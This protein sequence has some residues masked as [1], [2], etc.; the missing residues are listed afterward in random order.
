M[1]ARPI[2][3]IT[4]G[5]RGVGAAVARELAPTHGLILGGRESTTLHAICDELGARPWA[6]ELTDERAVAEA[7]AGI[8]R[9]DVL[10][11]SAGTAHLGRVADVPARQW[12]ESFEV[13][14]IAV[15][16]LT[17]L[18]LPALRASRGQV[19][20]INSG[21]GLR[22]NPGWAAY[23]ATKFAL[24]AFADA[25]RQEE[26]GDGVR[27]TSVFPGRVD[28]DLQRSVRE[29]EGGAYEPEKYLDAASVARAV[30]TAVT[31]SRDA[32][33]TEIVVRPAARP[34]A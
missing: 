30:A 33:F 9:L 17:R 15:A 4:G 5:S 22:V 28:T 11:H 14:V 26:E 12:R 27:V 21:S 1:D 3:L 7:V 23:A 13:N 16:N 10:V 6:V 8:D 19:V 25:L 34:T 2:A 32:H 24:R 18:L 20:L 29:Q 31:A